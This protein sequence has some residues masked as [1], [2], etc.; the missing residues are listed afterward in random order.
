[1]KT[2][3]LLQHDNRTHTS[4]KIMEHIDNLGYTVLPHPQYSSDFEPSDFHL[5]RLLKDGMHGKHFPSNNTI[6]A[7]VE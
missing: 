3:F 7:V 5:F 2:T 6:I 1:M 4:L